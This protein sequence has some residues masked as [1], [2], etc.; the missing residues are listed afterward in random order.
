MFWMKS[1]GNIC[2]FTILPAPRSREDELQAPLLAARARVPPTCFS[3][4]P[5]EALQLSK[6]QQHGAVVHHPRRG[7]LG[8]QRSLRCRESRRLPRRDL[9]AVRGAVYTHSPS[10]ILCFAS[11]RVAPVAR[12][13][14]ALLWRW[15]V[16]GA[17]R[18][19]QPPFCNFRSSP[20]DMADW[21]L[22]Y[23]RTLNSYGAILLDST[24]K[25]APIVPSTQT[26]HTHTWHSQHALIVIDAWPH[27]A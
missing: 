25:K 4:L 11:Q 18:A 8:L 19:E 1:R 16:F 26:D 12:A 10:S 24:L 14:D 3:L 5:Q 7:L 15:S 20:R 2:L 22:K 13:A 23:K 21:Y 9:Q 17:G 6:V 27:S